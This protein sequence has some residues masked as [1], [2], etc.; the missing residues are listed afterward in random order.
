M[1][2]LGNCIGVSYA[3]S[4]RVLWSE[5][6]SPWKHFKFIGGLAGDIPE[7]TPALHHQL[8]RPQA[9]MTLGLKAFPS[10]DKVLL[11]ALKSLVLS[12]SKLLLSG[13]NLIS[14]LA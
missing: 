3:V 11:A 10:G 4:D 5:N 13:A 2:H 7:T 14:E 12:C 1:N 9:S 6:A 8:R